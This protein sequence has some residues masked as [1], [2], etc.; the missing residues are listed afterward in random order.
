VQIFEEV[1]IGPLL[2]KGGFGEVYL[3]CWH[4][5]EVA[6]KLVQHFQS[7]CLD[8]G[9]VTT[10]LAEANLLQNLIHPNIVQL[11]A[12]ATRPIEVSANAYARSLNNFN[13]DEALETCLLLEFCNKGTLKEAIERGRFWRGRIQYGQ[14]D[15][16]V[17]LPTA[18]EIACALEFLHSNDILHGDLSS[19]NVLLA[20]SDQIPHGFTAKVADFGMCRRASSTILTST[21][22]TV[23]HMAPE[24]IEEGRLTKAADVFSFGVLLWSMYTGLQPWQGMTLSQIIYHVGTRGALLSIPIDCPSTLKDMLERCMNREHQS[25]PTFT[26]LVSELRLLI[27]V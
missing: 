14:A 20:S 7:S 21:L 26:K 2:G 6:V 4:G 24:L 10:G 3:G 1:Q 15:L 16:S 5:G 27:D 19:G 11:F 12:H 17:I 13:T 23:N 22:G 9:V 18:L 8:T 25:R